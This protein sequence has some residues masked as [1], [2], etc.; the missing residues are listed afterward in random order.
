MTD[1]VIFGAEG[2]IDIL[3]AVWCI[4]RKYPN[5]IHVNVNASTNMDVNSE[6]HHNNDNNIDDIISTHMSMNTNIVFVVGVAL[7]HSHLKYLNSQSRVVI[8]A[9]SAIPNINSYRNIRCFICDVYCSSVWGVLFPSVK[10]PIFISM[11]ASYTRNPPSRY[12]DP[13]IVGLTWNAEVDFKVFDTLHDHHATVLP[14]LIALGEHNIKVIDRIVTQL[15][16]KSTQILFKGYCCSILETT[17]MRPELSLYLANEDH[18]DMSIVWWYHITADTFV[19]WVRR[20]IESSINLMDLLKDCNPKGDAE[21]VVIYVD[22]TEM[23]IGEFLRMHKTP[24]RIIDVPQY[25]SAIAL[26]G[27]VS[28]T[29]PQSLD[30]SQSPIKSTDMM[31]GK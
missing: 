6:D 27:T 13:F 29:P 9:S 17:T 2:N 14:K 4:R 11:L 25:Y 22:A 16:I 19:L 28:Y 21:S 15:A 23:S 18:V 31:G 3:A 7:S 24:T 10:Q 1:A 20:K 26:R 8:F 30:M 12:A 5:P